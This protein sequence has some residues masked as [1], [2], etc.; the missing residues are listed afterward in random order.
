MKPPK[1]ISRLPEDY[2]KLTKKFLK[3]A[4]KEMLEACSQK[5]GSSVLYHSIYD[6]DGNLI[7]CLE[8]IP[9][10]CK[11]LL[12]S[13]ESP[14]EEPNAVSKFKGLIDARDV[15]GYK[16]RRWEN[17]QDVKNRILSINKD[18]TD[19]QYMQWLDK[20]KGTFGAENIDIS[21]NK[22]QKN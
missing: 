2:V 7:S 13:P 22:H 21:L 11:I 19:K 16:E 1:N 17:A 5:M 10:D 20:V 6:I 3:R 14:P 8:D 12:L 15:Q 4:F 9:L 18:W